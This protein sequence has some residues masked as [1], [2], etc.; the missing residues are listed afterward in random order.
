MT[1][2]CISNLNKNE[3]NWGSVDGYADYEVSWLGRVRHA[4][5]KVIVE[6]RTS[7]YGYSMAHLYKNG[8]GKPHYVHRLVA[9]TWVANSSEK[10]CVDHIDGN[11]ANNNYENLRF[12]TYAENSQNRKKLTN[13]TNTTSIYKGVCFKPASKKW[14][15]R[16]N[17]NKKEKFLGSYESEE[18]AA[19]AYNEAAVELF[20]DF[21]K[22]NITED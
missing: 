6:Q 1:N 11:R 4:A 15:A 13:T 16:I 10:P 22:L 21:A 2:I 8:K 18:E 12:A 14:N 9:S 17:I 20:T 3:E 5:T 19:K 7:T